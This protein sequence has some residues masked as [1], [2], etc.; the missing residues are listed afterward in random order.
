ML[1]PLGASTQLVIVGHRVRIHSGILVFC[2]TNET[3][4]RPT[5]SSSGRID[6]HAASLGWKG[7]IHPQMRN[8]INLNCRYRSHFTDN[9][10]LLCELW[11]IPQHDTCVSHVPC[12]AVNKYLSSTDRIGQHWTAPHHPQYREV[13]QSQVAFVEISCA[14]V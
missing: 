4:R 9:P 1:L 3:T 13:V 10:G 12:S 5:A 11:I 2:F 6:N 8:N 7:V 14:D